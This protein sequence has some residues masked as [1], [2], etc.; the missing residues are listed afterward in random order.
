MNSFFELLCYRLVCFAIFR[1]ECLI[2]AICASAPAFASVAVWA[3][4]SCVYGYFLHLIRENTFQ[5]ITKIFIWFAVV[6]ILILLWGKFMKCFVFQQMKVCILNYS[7]GSE[8][9]SF[10]NWEDLN[11][12]KRKKGIAKLS[13][14]VKLYFHN[15]W[16]KNFII[17]ETL[18]SQYMKKLFHKHEKS[19]SAAKKAWKCNCVIFRL[20]M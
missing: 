17:Y 20:M 6:H 12:E 5:K 14:I 1:A 19:F 4:E 7:N 13:Y 3:G 10:V 9:K 8:W 2:V 16:Q 11:W 18:F 15:I